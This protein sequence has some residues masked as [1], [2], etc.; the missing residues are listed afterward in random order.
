MN[1]S[2]KHALIR[3]ELERVNTE[4]GRLTPAV[5]VEEATDSGAPLHQF[6]E[7]DDTI[8]AARFRLNQAAALIRSVKIHITNER[9]GE[10]EEVTI[11][12]WVA[13]KAAGP[14]TEVRDGYLPQAEVYGDPVLRAAVLRKIRRE[15]MSL[16]RRYRHLAEFW[17]ILDEVAQQREAS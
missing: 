7:W 10:T 17:E 16:Q 15:I 12:A 1:P 3:S 4:R 9:G 8:A 14:E 5:V 13:A 11:R 6:F 2:T